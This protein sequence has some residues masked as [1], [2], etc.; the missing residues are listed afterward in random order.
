VA[1]QK[2][3]D[4]KCQGLFHGFADNVRQAIVL[5]AMEDVPSTCKQNRLTFRL[6]ILHGGR[7]KSCIRKRIWKMQ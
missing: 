1:A 3:E 7:R 5:V 4:A 6:N 2:K